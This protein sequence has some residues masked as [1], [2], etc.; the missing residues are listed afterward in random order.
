MID[1]PIL[2]GLAVVVTDR[3]DIPAGSVVH[4]RRGRAE[5]MLQCASL[6]D[7]FHEER[8]RPFLTD[9][10]DGSLEAS[11]SM[12][13]GHRVDAE[14]S[15]GRRTVDL[16]MRR[17]SSR[18]LTSIAAS[19]QLEDAEPWTT[20]SALAV[21]CRTAAA[22]L[23]LHPGH[24]MIAEGDRLRLALAGWLAGIH[25]RTGFA[26]ITA[27][28]ASPWD[29]AVV[30]YDAAATERLVSGR[31]GLPAPKPRGIAILD[32]ADSTVLGSIVVPRTGMDVMERLRATA[33]Y[34][35][36]IA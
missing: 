27:S 10:S 8:S 28:A 22:A 11:W 32:D 35:E 21:L 20:A 3:T 36:S 13:T 14:W 30:W 19:A 26:A 4:E 1:D 23:V 7:H 16:S 9:F 18:I 31:I 2:N 15:A 12:S 29:D 34:R 24:P 17:T 33:A 5:R 25:D 6:L